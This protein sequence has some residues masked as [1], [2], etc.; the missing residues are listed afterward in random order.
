MK[1]HEEDKY[2][3]KLKHYKR[4]QAKPMKR[5]KKSK[6]NFKWSIKEMSEMQEFLDNMEIEDHNHYVIL[7]KSKTVSHTLDSK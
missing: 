7:N 3:F 1:C 2:C 5:P 4:P 6:S